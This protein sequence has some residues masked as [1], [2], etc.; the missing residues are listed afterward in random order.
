MNLLEIPDSHPHLLHHYCSFSDE[1]KLDWGYCQ[2]VA[3]RPRS[4]NDEITRPAWSILI[5]WRYSEPVNT[6]RT[7]QCASHHAESRE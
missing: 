1:K 6:D 4:V 2:V 7:I 5:N 3:D